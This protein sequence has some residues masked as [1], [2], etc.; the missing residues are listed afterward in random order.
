M[1]EK[2]RLLFR[3]MKNLE[4]LTL[5]LSIDNSNNTF[6]NGNHVYNILIRM[7]QLRLFNFYFFVI[8]SLNHLYEEDIRSYSNTIY[9]KI[10]CIVEHQYRNIECQIFSSP[11]MFD[12][13][14]YIANAFTNFMFI[15]VKRLMVLC[16]IRER[17]FH[18]NC[19]VFSFT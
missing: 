11:F 12:Y 9:Q 6:I 14:A 15:H 17:I 3:C 10:N 2:L 18:S 7:R 19:F 16:S 5:F 1:I 13:L 8:L 4:E